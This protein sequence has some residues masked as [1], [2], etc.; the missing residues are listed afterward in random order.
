MLALQRQVGNRAL[1]QLIAP[2]NT[3][4]TSRANDIRRYFSYT[5]GKAEAAEAQFHAQQKAAD[6]K[7][8]VDAKTKKTTVTA[9]SRPPLRVANDGRIAIESSDLKSR[10]AKVFFAEN[11]VVNESNAR[12]LESGSKY[13]LFTD[14]GNNVKVPSSTSAQPLHNLVSVLPRNMESKDAAKGTYGDEGLT[15][16]VQATCDEVAQAIVHTGNIGDY[17]VLK[18]SLKLAVGFGELNVAKYILAREK[19]ESADKAVD[20]VSLALG[21]EHD[22]ELKA[23]TKTK[24]AE[25]EA[26][27]AKQRAEMIE[28][29]AKMPG[30][31][32]AA[33]LAAK[34]KKRAEGAVRAEMETEL[35]QGIADAYGKLLA[36]KPDLVDTLSAELGIN[37]QAQPDVGQ[38]FGSIMMAGKNRSLDH[39]TGK[40]RTDEEGGKW[41]SHYGGVV[42]KSGDDVITLEN[43]ARNRENEGIGGATSQLYY[44]QMYGSQAGQ[45]WHEVWSNT[46]RRV[47]NPLTQVFGKSYKETWNGQL[48]NIPRLEAMGDLAEYVEIL[49][50][51]QGLVS[52]AADRDKAM[53]AYKSGLLTLV[54]SRFRRYAQKAHDVAIDSGVAHFADPYKL[55]YDVV[56]PQIDTWI[57]TG[58][59]A[60]GMPKAKPS[61]QWPVFAE[62]LAQL[63]THITLLKS[64]YAERFP[65]EDL[66]A[67][68]AQAKAAPQG[69][70]KKLSPKKQAALE[71]K[72]KAYLDPGHLDATR[73]KDLKSRHAHY[74][75]EDTDATSNPTIAE[76]RKGVA[77]LRAMKLPENQIRA[78][79]KKLMP[80]YTDSEI[81]TYL[82]G[83]TVPKVAYLESKDRQD[84]AL[85][86]EGGKLKQRGKPFDT[87]AMFSSGA[88]A[89]FSI[90]VMSPGGEI[91]ANEHKP[92]L[93]HHSSFLAG[94][95]TAA[96]GELQ[97]K[98]G[99]L[100]HLTNKSGHYHPGAAQTYQ[101][102]RELKQRGIALSSFKLKIAGIP[103]DKPDAKFNADYS[104]ARKFADEF[105]TK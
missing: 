23:R 74:A 58:G 17:P 49:N 102:V 31:E 95:P 77:Q 87:S 39:K 69:G 103:E 57:A 9:A 94:L 51:Y 82:M 30:A 97:V 50:K 27:A 68:D 64:Y 76:G 47:I 24:T 66:K 21:A 99:T 29:K 60:P 85:E 15:M 35:K 25:F 71:K 92:G 55:S 2:P 100:Q 48:A 104:N 90:F 26:T 4:G 7:S 81:D 3:P 79:I 38:A 59:R 63:R 46:D 18:K 20:A 16:D 8:F 1:S 54:V 70:E 12:L 42:A 91:F 37:K 98:K 105:E 44:F 72:V 33:E 40:V 53:A 28:A 34:D 10:Q 86:T 52:Q 101:V 73:Y 61:A 19:G 56:L 22:D 93:F 65:A 80:A 89:G 14:S 13:Q 45:T 78:E 67:A 62:S 96:A 43:Y 5:P 32:E 84:Y 36:A 75:G 88:G 83:T 11:S 6:A 41:G